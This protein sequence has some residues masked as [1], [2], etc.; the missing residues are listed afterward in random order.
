MQL[1]N[2]ISVSYL[3]RST[4]EERTVYRQF[5]L[6]AGRSV[7][8]GRNGL[9]ITDGGDRV[10]RRH[11]VIRR[12]E[13]AGLYL[14]DTSSNGT[15]VLDD[16][17]GRTNIL[18]RRGEVVPLGKTIKIA[19]GQV[20]MK[21]RRGGLSKSVLRWPY[22]S[23]YFTCGMVVGK[24]FYLGRDWDE[25]DLVLSEEDNTVSRRHALMTP[26]Q[27]GRFRLKNVSSRNFLLFNNFKM[28]KSGDELTASAGDAFSMGSQRVQ[29]LD[30][31]QPMLE[32][33]NPSCRLL[34]L[35]DHEMECRWCGK[36][37]S[38]GKTVMIR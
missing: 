38:N 15:L 1:E 7:E 9:Q 3:D 17:R 2:T 23:R 35:L 6:E 22:H 12:G 19:V 31:N 34:N 32:C 11:F 5:P 26:L 10:S 13:G 8:Q 27:G 29:L 36:H 21:I 37:L 18:L 4:G 24:P 28:L 16:G 25:A 30:V 20:E 33:Q 14:E